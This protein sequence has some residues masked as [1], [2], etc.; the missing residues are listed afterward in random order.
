MSATAPHP[1]PDLQI[2]ELT[3]LHL[4][5]PVLAGWHHHEW[6]HLYAPEV[7]NH[8]TAVRELEAMAE[9]GSSDRTWV[10]F[11]GRSRSAEAVLGSVSLVAS[12]D[13]HGF[14]HLTPWLASM[15]VVPAARG[16]G[17]ATA[18][19]DALL[20][21]ARADGYEVVHLFTSG[22]E[23]FWA[24]RGWRVVAHV[25]AAGHPATVMARSTHLHRASAEMG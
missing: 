21:G 1:P 9:P 7:W 12:D 2:Q 8:A 16:R 18:L 5:A 11:R 10:A 17:V 22:H 20:A 19:A 3:G 15:F 4:L 14:D 6:G 24:D 13:L 23:R 25:D